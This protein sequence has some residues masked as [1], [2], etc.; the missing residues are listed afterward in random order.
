[1]IFTKN[2]NGQDR[3]CI[4][5]NLPAVHPFMPSSFMYPGQHSY[6]TM[7]QKGMNIWNLYKLVTVNSWWS[8]SCNVVW[9]QNMK[10]DSCGVM[11]SIKHTEWQFQKTSNKAHK[12]RTLKKTRNTT[13]LHKKQRTVRLISNEQDTK[14]NHENTCFAA[15]TL[16]SSWYFK[17][18]NMKNR[19]VCCP[20]ALSLGC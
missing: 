16:Y 11:N 10:K 6:T 18:V 15:Y 12:S 17:Y 9:L 3:P 7:L 2:I 20:T 14:T 13:P 4:V 19:H 8:K 1:M 5:S